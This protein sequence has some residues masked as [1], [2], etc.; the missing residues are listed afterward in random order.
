MQEQP[1]QPGD[2]VYLKSGS[3][4]MTV[5]SIS[6]DGCVSVNCIWFGI[7]QDVNLAAIQTR[8]GGDYHHTRNGSELKYGQFNP[9]ALCKR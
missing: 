3:P 2:V 9:A 4:P 8:M 7:E 1:F 6:S 5:D